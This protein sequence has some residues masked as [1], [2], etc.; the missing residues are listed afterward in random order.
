MKKANFAMA[1][2]CYQPVDNFGWTIE[3]AYKKAYLPL[4]ETLEAFPEIKA[5]FHYS[6]NMLEWFEKNHPEYIDKISSLIDKRQIEL[7]GGGYCEPV[8]ALI[9]QHD[10]VGQINM[11]SAIM[12]RLFGIKPE[13]AWIAEKVWLPELVDT[14][15]SVNVKYT[16]I[17][18]NHLQQAGIAPDDFFGPYVAK[19]EKGEV[20]LFP[21]LT[22]LRYYLPFRTPA[23][24]ID[25]I[26]NAAANS[27]CKKPCF[28]FADDG[29]KFGLW[30]HTYKWVH[31]KG[32][33]R[34]F[35]QSLKDNSEWLSTITYCEALKNS[36]PER[37]VDL[38]SSSYA[39]MIEWSG[40]DFR[41]FLKKY[42]ES[43]RMHRRMISLSGQ[44]EE[45]GQA[46]KETDDNAAIKK[47][48]KELF[49]AQSNC[50]YWHGIFGGLYLPHLRSGVY[51]HLIKAQNIMD[52]LK[53]ESREK[54]RAIEYKAEE[55]N[56]ETIIRNNYLDIF[57]RPFDGGS[58][59]ELDFK[60][61]NVNL[62]NI[63]SR[64]KEKYH[65]KLERNQ[66]FRM[67]MARR[68][69]LRGEFPDIH[70][71]LG[72]TERGLRKILNYDSYRRASFLT[73]ILEEEFSWQELD[74]GVCGNEHFL[75][76]TYSG[77]IQ[78]DNSK[79]SYILKKRDKIFT[80]SNKSFDLEVIKKI[81]VGKEKEISFYQR[82][83]KYSDG[84]FLFKHAVE[85]NLSIFDNKLSSKP[86][87]SK[88][89]SIELK[90]AYSSLR[91]DLAMD[92][93]MVIYTYPVFTVN[94]SE[95]GLGS[96][97]QGLSI[98]VGEEKELSKKEDKSE[99]NIRLKIEK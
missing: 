89:K 71:I 68:A 2:H 13:G 46:A 49:K 69:M 84:K 50:A 28:F 7:I 77:N 41:N 96:T 36:D 45:R 10:R 19:G 6:G 40:G 67:M 12:D 29:E 75:K 61:G 55:G 22:K 60:P 14:L 59:G 47:A 98:I 66:K 42:P 85:F 21:S 54:I 90:D 72:V 17:D 64:V 94:E 63:V 97:Y 52:D 56:S 70:D 87:L 80:S 39:E 73:H 31:E 30:P 95:S 82:A 78:S 58:V 38:P 37:V 15:V 48:Q 11:N 93:N 33:L 8:M 88:G 99:I 35:F 1:F 34:K 57:I 24:T 9:P 4:L 65:K 27:S 86:Q 83:K 23:T 3:E 92:R 76:G 5:T 18:D 25:F 20:T 16:I 53:K 32:W 74:K 26:K 91:L 44:I 79:L 51:E 43:G 81:N 62:T